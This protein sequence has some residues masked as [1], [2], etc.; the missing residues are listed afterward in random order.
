MSDASQKQ[1]KL[2]TSIINLFI[3]YVY[4]STCVVIKYMFKLS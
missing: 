2:I 1:H 3:D 4:E